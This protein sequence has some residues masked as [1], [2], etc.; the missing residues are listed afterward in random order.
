L[1]TDNHTIATES[2]NSEKAVS[3]ST[4]M[5]RSVVIS[6]AVG[7]L[8]IGVLAIL[9]VPGREPVS[10]TFLRYHRWPPVPS[11]IHT[12]ATLKLT[13]NSKKT[14]TYLTDFGGGIFLFLRKTPEG[15]TNTSIPVSSAMFMDR[16]GGKLTPGYIFADPA[17]PRKP[18]EGA[19]PVRIR[20][21]KPG[22]SIEVYVGV[23]PDTLPMRVGIVC[24]TPQGK[25]AQQLGNWIGRAK[26][27]CHIKSKP[28]GLFEVWCDEPMQ[29]SSAPPNSEKH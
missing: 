2:L 17:V 15:W 12:G 6:V 9:L 27:W 8:L 14:I 11:A 24:R 20:E 23:E 22:Q 21:L 13:N 29:I 3:K 4:V 1:A 25:L 10:L 26:I 18:G 19:S 16:P 5:K 7:V 28:P